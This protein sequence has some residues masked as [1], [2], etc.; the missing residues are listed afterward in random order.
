M[1]GCWLRFDWLAQRSGD[2]DHPRRGEEA[3]ERLVADHRVALDDLVAAGEIGA[4]VAGQVQAA[5]EAAAWHVWRSSA[6]MTCYKAAP[7]DYA[8]ASSEQ[9]VRQAEVLAQMAAEGDLDPDVV[10]RAQAAVERDVAFLALSDEET[11]ALYAKLRKAAGDTYSFPGF[12]QLDLEIS[13][14]SAEAARFLVEL[15]LGE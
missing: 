14:E 4:A 10:A 9:L 3:L 7:P 12:D 2:W 11:K 6:P 5:F 15:L 1:R 13:P 8:P